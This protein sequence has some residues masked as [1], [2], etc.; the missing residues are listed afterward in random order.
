[1]AGKQRCSRVTL[2]HTV[3]YRWVLQK[4]GFQCGCRQPFETMARL[5]LWEG[6]RLRGGTMGYGVSDEPK[7][8]TFPGSGA[9]PSCGG[10]EGGTLLEM[11]LTALPFHSHITE[12]ASLPPIATST[13]VRGW[14][15]LPRR[16][17]TERHV[18][19]RGYTTTDKLHTGSLYSN[20]LELD[21]WLEAGW[22][23][24]YFSHAYQMHI[25]SSTDN[26]KNTL[27]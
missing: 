17:M 1:M 4:Q 16:G 27:L 21:G 11:A 6:G 23:K 25:C 10:V 8:L 3:H 22:I 26:F 9:V 12:A 20:E 19:R 24:F 13:Q 14:T 18:E 2:K 5:E 7:A 15:A